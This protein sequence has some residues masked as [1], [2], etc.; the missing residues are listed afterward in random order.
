MLRH[1]QK[2][3]YPHESERYL[4]AKQ[5]YQLLL[6][7]CGTWPVATCLRAD[8]TF[9]GES[10]KK[11]S[12]PKASRKGP[13]SRPPRKSASSMRTPQRRSAKI[14]RLCAGPERAVTRAVRIGEFSAGKAVC[15]RCNAVRKPRNGPTD[16]GVS[17]C[18]RSLR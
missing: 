8:S 9:A 6:T 15:R 2:H 3:G 1:R 12:A 4:S 11:I 13:L 5:G 10:S 14:T 7:P 16:R 17:A 18:S